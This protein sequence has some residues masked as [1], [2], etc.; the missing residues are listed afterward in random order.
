MKILFWIL[1]L[2]E[3]TAE[4]LH[5]FSERNYAVGKGKAWGKSIAINTFLKIFHTTHWKAFLVWS[6]GFSEL[7]EAAFVQMLWC[8]IVS[9][10]LQ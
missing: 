5:G 3:E 6:V 1:T 9:D 8:S 4:W 7:A 2:P 10:G